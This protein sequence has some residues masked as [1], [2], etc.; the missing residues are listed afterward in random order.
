MWNVQMKQFFA[1]AIC[2]VLSDWSRLYGTI[3]SLQKLGLR[4]FQRGCIAGKV[5]DGLIELHHDN[6]RL[7]GFDLRA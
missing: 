7:D 4:L 3:S 2:M 5:A 1:T 6:W